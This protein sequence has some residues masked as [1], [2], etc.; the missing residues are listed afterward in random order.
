[1]QNNTS[2]Q[3]LDT[4]S[5]KATE[6]N[7]IGNKFEKYQDFMVL[8]DMQNTPFVIEDNIFKNAGNN[9]FGINGDTLAI[10][11]YVI[12]SNGGTI[13]NNTFF[14]EEEGTCIRLHVGVTNNVTIKGNSFVYLGAPRTSG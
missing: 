8:N 7:C 9:N 13:K 6:F 12:E 1:M 10:S 11:L 5:M 4:T 3:V 14:I 2:N